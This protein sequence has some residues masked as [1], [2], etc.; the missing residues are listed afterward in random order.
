M[1][2]IGRLFEEEPFE[3]L[4]EKDMPVSGI[5]FWVLT[6][7]NTMHRAVRKRFKDSKNAEMEPDSFATFSEAMEIAD[8]YAVEIKNRFRNSAI[9]RI[10]DEIRDDEFHLY[11]VDRMNIPIAKIGVVGEDYR[12][13]T[14]H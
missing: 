3:E 6:E 1:Q 2:P 10:A 14:R 7:F 9:H 4:A 12:K 11:I 13:Q 8:E 5:C